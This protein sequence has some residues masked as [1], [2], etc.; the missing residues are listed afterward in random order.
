[1]QRLALDSVESRDC[2]GMLLLF[3]NAE[4]AWKRTGETQKAKK[5][6]KMYNAVE[7]VHQKT[8]SRKRVT[9]EIPNFSPEFI[10]KAYTKA[11]WWMFDVRSFSPA[12]RGKMKRGY[13]CLKKHY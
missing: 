3:E 1:M 5:A 9:L 4:R 12:K 8:R 7:K 13:N 11:D 6:K 2:E 10:E